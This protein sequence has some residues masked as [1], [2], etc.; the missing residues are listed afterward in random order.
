M[1][2]AILVAGLGSSLPRTRTCTRTCGQAQAQAQAWIGVGACAEPEFSALRVFRRLAGVEAR[3]V[4]LPVPGSFHSRDVL[5]CA[6]VSLFRGWMAA[7]RVALLTYTGPDSAVRVGLRVQE[8]LQAEIM[9][10]RPAVVNGERCVQAVLAPGGRA[11][12]SESA[13]RLA[14]AGGK[15]THRPE[16]LLFPGRNC[17]NSV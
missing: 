7:H 12:G 1:R 16:S 3:G 4:G 5:T 10:T 14:A 13:E 2:S 9:T 6:R 11:R 17:V 8:V 15:F